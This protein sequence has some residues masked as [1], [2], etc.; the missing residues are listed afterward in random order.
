[1]PRHPHAIEP[2]RRL[3]SALKNGTPFLATGH[4]LAGTRIVSDEDVALLHRE[5][6]E[7]TQLDA[8]AANQ[9]GGDLVEYRRHNQ[10]DIRLLQM[11]VAGAKLGD[12]F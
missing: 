4:W 6:A 8:C 11:R 5:D 7:T 1:L 3:L 12:E 9:C 2:Q 10:L